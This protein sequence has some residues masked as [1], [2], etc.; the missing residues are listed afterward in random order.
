MRTPASLLHSHS[1]IADTPSPAALLLPAHVE[2]QQAI[3]VDSDTVVILSSLLCA[4]ICVAGLALVARCAC[5]R[6]GGASV[7]VSATTSG[8]RSSAQAPRGLEKAAIEALPTVSVSSSLKQAS[9]RDAADKEECAIC[10]A[11]FVEGDQLRVLPRCAHGFHAAC[12][13][14]WL[15]AHA[16]CPSCRATIVSVVS[17]LCRRCGAACCDQ[18]EETPMAAPE[19]AAAGRG[20]HA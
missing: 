12:V 19:P 8:G 11:A 2:E 10:L 9:R 7:S 13:D 1:A 15:A 6:G 17:P 14:T 4:L 18:Q 5:R 3:S 20:L 16:S